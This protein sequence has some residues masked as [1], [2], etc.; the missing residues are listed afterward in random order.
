MEAED[1]SQSQYGNHNPTDRPGSPLA[2]HSSN[3]SRRSSVPSEVRNNVD[4]L[5]VDLGLTDDDLRGLQQT[6]NASQVLTTQDEEVIF[7][8]RTRIE[9][10]PRVCYDESSPM[11]HP[12]RR[13]TIDH[14]VHVDRANRLIDQHLKTMSTPMRTTMTY[15]PN[16]VSDPPQVERTSAYFVTTGAGGG[17][18][19]SEPSSS[20]SDTRGSNGNNNGMDHQMALPMTRMMTTSD[21]LLRIAVVVVDVFTQMDLVLVQ[22]VDRFILPDNVPTILTS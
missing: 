18:P 13:S 20:S 5:Q 10:T 4:Q 21:H 14:N 3:A 6:P 11:M 17:G 16:I 1:G 12:A 8:N 7:G 2:P 22:P 19:P 9:D 15:N